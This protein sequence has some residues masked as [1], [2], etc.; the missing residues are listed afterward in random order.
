MTMSLPALQLSP[1]STAAPARPTWLQRR[2]G[3]VLAVGAL[4]AGLVQLASPAAAA[5]T[6]A[7]VAPAPFGTVYRAV[8]PVRVMNRVAIGPGGIYTLTIPGVPSG[9]EAVQLNITATEATSITYISAC[10][11]D[12]ALAACRTTSA[13]NP[14][15]RVDTPASALVA[16][17]GAQGNTVK[18]YNNAGSVKLIADVEGYY[19]PASSGGSV[20]IPVT[21]YRAL[22]ARTMG[23][24]SNLTLDLPG[25]P[26]G[27]TAVAL[28][29]TSTGASGVSYVS[30]CPGGQALATCTKT[31]V[32]NPAPGIDMP[33]AAVVKLGG[34]NNRQVRIYNNAATVS[35][36]ADVSGFFVDAASA[37]AGSGYL[38]ATTPVRAVDRKPMAQRSA[39]SFALSG[40]PA[41]ATS[42][43]LNVTATGSTAVSFVSTC[44]GGTSTSTCSKS[45]TL[46]PRPG[47]DTANTVL[48][49]LGGAK[50]D[51]VTLYNNAGATKLIADV[52]GYFV[53]D[54]SPAPDLPQPAPAP[55]PVVVSTGMPGAGSTGV[56]AGTSLSPSG[57]IVVTQANTVIDGMDVSGSITVRASGVV[58]KNSRI[59]GTGSYGVYTQ[60]GSVTIYDSEIYGFENAIGFDNWT[61][62]RVNIHGTYGDGVKLGS[63]VTLQDSW[64]HDLTP[65]A[66]AHSDGGQMQSG[67]TNLVVRNNVI[68]LASTPNANAALFLA[69]DLGPST[70]GPVT[71]E[72]N[73]LDGGNYT[74]FC[75]DGNNGQYLVGNMK[76]L[77]NKFGRHSSY[78]PSRVNVPITQS[79]NVWA[80]TGAALSL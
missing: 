52:Q 79:G 45:S 57:G 5:G 76:F 16:L 8:E 60:S 56:P 42:V 71:I 26:A 12:V 73:W 35:V 19:V 37:P 80:D 29:L 25:A 70:A 67:V 48:V 72:G 38:Q 66:G 9:A 14:A 59:H 46:N 54:G 15:P 40:V 28:N 62:V 78:G 63:N 53:G 27:A 10:A 65:A 24:Q 7:T 1:R 44:P 69:P 75:V 39:Y 43:A 3:A 22:A 20:F 77:G 17:G 47:A 31:S 2:R 34:T 74:L 36:I 13:L 6:V 11:G 33:N 30:V 64:I 55:A 58:I 32:L 41:G 4:V 68:D 23:S 51:T 18:L 50:R 61:A 21:P 49:K